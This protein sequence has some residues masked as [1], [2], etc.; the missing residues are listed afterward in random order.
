[1]DFQILLKRTNERKYC[2]VGVVNNRILT[3]LAI[4]KLETINKTLMQ[5]HTN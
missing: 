2:N 3:T 5:H 1:M 4:N